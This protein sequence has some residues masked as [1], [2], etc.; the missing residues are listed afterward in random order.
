[1]LHENISSFIA[2]ETDEILVCERTAIVDVCTIADRTLRA[3]P[4]SS[5]DE[6]MVLAPSLPHHPRNIYTTCRTAFLSSC[7]TSITVPTLIVIEV[8]EQEY[9]LSSLILYLMRLYG[10]IKCICVTASFTLPSWYFAY[11]GASSH[12]FR[13]RS[14]T[15]HIDHSTDI[16]YFGD[17]YPGDR[18][19][20]VLCL[21]AQNTTR[22]VTTCLEQQP[23]YV[24]VVVMLPTQSMCEKVMRRLEILYPGMVTCVYTMTTP[25]S[26]LRTARVLL[27]CET[28]IPED[29]IS[30]GCVV[31]FGIRHLVYFTEGTQPSYTSWSSCTKNELD[32]RIS[33][34]G[35][36]SPCLVYRVM[37]EETYKALP[38]E[39]PPQ[40]IYI[41]MQ[42]DIAVLLTMVCSETYTHL[43]IFLDVCDTDREK[44]T[45]ETT[46]ETRHDTNDPYRG[47]KSNWGRISDLRRRVDM[48]R[49]I[50]VASGNI[51]CD[52]MLMPHLRANTETLQL[53]LST[54]HFDAS[55][56]PGICQLVSLSRRPSCRATCNGSSLAVVTM[57]ISFVDVVTTYGQLSMISDVDVH[58]S[59]WIGVMKRLAHRY[60]LSCRSVQ[61]DTHVFLDLMV[62][63]LLTVLHTRLFSV[64]KVRDHV[65][66]KFVQRW[67]FLSSLVG[68]TSSSTD[69][70]T[71]LRTM[72]NMTR[73]CTKSHTWFLR[74]AEYASMC[75][76]SGT[77]YTL[78]RQCQDDV[79]SVLWRL[80]DSMVWRHDL[81]P[82]ARRSSF[83]LHGRH[84]PRF[85]LSH[86]FC[87]SWRCPH[88]VEKYVVTLP[89]EIIKAAAAYHHRRRDMLRIKK[90]FED[91]VVREIRDEVAYRPGMCKFHECMSSFT[92]N[93]M[94][95]SRV[96]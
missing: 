96:S 32:E 39:Q 65:W 18:Y 20:T 59:V 90:Y 25:R 14:I 55:L 62:E 72:Q 36:Y 23:S 70:Q 75:A 43:M 27:T 68:L 60:D 58:K 80:Q 79:A 34:C 84:D 7:F 85:H 78:T 82:Y 4:S 1:M 81:P 29:D 45:C 40:D 54:K 83:L 15:N 37:S 76:P 51:T 63:W 38:T 42:T 64:L 26:Q 73:P 86:G 3:S 92:H 66:R 52:G 31:D 28:Y 56:F 35:R 22:I 5:Y 91:N 47:T 44:K 94:T 13:L 69:A 57:T 46:Y 24:T 88:S 67:M 2:S 93:I 87:L 8:N 11:H 19:K 10:H 12:T 16:V 89:A 77:W 48:C 33:W 30:V 50:L 53:L 95:M 74:D 17:V 71:F 61:R 41:M 21:D 9:I 49:R 6:Y